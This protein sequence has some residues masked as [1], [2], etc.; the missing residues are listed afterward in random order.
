M[1]STEILVWAI[2]AAITIAVIYSFVMQKILLS[3]SKKLFDQNC[4]SIEN[5]KTLKELG[6]K[7]ILVIT[8]ADYFASVKYG[9][10]RAIET[11][12]KSSKKNND[13][14]FTE[15]EELKYFLPK[16]NITKSISKHMTEKTPVLIIVGLLLILFVMAYF[17][18]DIIGFLGNYAKGVMNS[19]KN[20]PIGIEQKDDSLLKDQ[21]QLNNLPFFEEDL[22]QDIQEEQNT[23]E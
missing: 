7:N 17:A 3:L 23:K 13:I 6:Y 20:A 18:N 10:A 16:E 14:L 2:F 12:K 1:T 5:A 4:D 11:D 21:E 9:L 15:K 8:L 19:G 22:T